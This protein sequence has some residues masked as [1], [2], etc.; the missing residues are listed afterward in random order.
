LPT[1]NSIAHNLNPLLNTAPTPSIPDDVGLEV[2]DSLPLEM[3]DTG[4]TEEVSKNVRRWF[5]SLQDEKF[6]SIIKVAIE[7]GDTNQTLVDRLFEGGYGKDNNTTPYLS[8][9]G[10]A[11]KTAYR[12][13]SE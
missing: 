10:N 4:G 12:L 1:G 5:K 6:K 3:T 9:L 7:N 8:K 11:I 13:T 2:N